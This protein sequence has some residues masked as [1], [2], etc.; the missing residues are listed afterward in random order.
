[1]FLYKY[2]ECSLEMRH[3]MNPEVTQKKKKQNKTKQLALK[4]NKNVYLKTNIY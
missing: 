1:M 4:L 2:S 3:S